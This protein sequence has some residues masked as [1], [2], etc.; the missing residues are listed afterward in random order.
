M[1]IHGVVWK[2]RVH[3][4]ARKNDGESCDRIWPGGLQRRDHP[5]VCPRSIRRSRRDPVSVVCSLRWGLCCGIV[6]SEDKRPP[7][8]LKGIFPFLNK[9]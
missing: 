8:Y 2:A 6:G 5:A 1:W 7:L 3:L 9:G 4:E